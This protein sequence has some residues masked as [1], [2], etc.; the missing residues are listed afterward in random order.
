VL[1]PDLYQAALT[2][3]KIS[4]QL[5]HLPVVGDQHLPTSHRAPPP[6][7]PTIWNASLDPISKREPHNTHTTH[8]SRPPFHD[9]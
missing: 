9:R 3:L 4:G 7:L 5:A 1:A 2:M 6:N 8:G